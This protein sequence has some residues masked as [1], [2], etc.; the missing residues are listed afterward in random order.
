[1]PLYGFKCKACNREEE[2]LIAWT[3]LDAVKNSQ[4]CEECGGRMKILVSVPN[5]K[6]DTEFMAGSH[7]D[8]GLP[9]DWARGEAYGKAKAAGV[10]IQG[11]KFHPGLCRRGKSFDPEAWYGGRDEVIQ[12]TEALGRCVEGT[13]NHVS[14]IRDKDLKAAEAPYRVAADIVAPKAQEIINNQHGGVVSAEKRTQIVEELRDKHSGV[15]DDPGPMTP[16]KLF[17][18]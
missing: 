5:L 11:K 3:R 6:T 14:P 13:V 18:G 12:K 15:M 10:N 1:M 8:D 2:K 7:N 4:C 9:G 17:A 16:E